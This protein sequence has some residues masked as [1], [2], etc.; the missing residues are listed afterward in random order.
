MCRCVVQLN[1]TFCVPAFLLSNDVLAVE[2]YH[3]FAR[4]SSKHLFKLSLRGTCFQTLQQC[5]DQINRWVINAASAMTSTALYTYKLYRLNYISGVCQSQ[6]CSVYVFACLA[7]I[8]MGA[9]RCC[10]RL[11]LT[12]YIFLLVCLRRTCRTSWVD[13]QWREEVQQF[14]CTWALLIRW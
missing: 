2:L 5:Q 7:G 9:L 13:A 11:A 10:E 14:T 1:W 6:A 12:T 4:T 3:Q 8:P